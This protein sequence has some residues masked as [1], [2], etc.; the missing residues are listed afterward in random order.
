MN[1]QQDYHLTQAALP[2]FSTLNADF[3]RASRSRYMKSI[4]AL[5][6]RQ[7]AVESDQKRSCQASQG[8]SQ[9]GQG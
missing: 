6:R 9:R 5:I 1:Q 3:I 7:P 2:N 8:L 4:N